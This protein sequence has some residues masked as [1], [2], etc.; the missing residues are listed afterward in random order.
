MKTI[1]L[2]RHAK[3][4][5]H[6][7]SISDF[8]RV[9]T[10]RGIMEAGEM[11][12]RLRE[13]GERPDLIVSSPAA[14]A[15]ETAE[16]F[17]ETLD[18]EPGMIRTKSEIYSGHIDVLEEVVRSLPGEIESVMIFGHNPTISLFGSWLANRGI[19]QMET[20]GVLRMD[21]MKK[22]WADLKKGCAAAVWYLQPVRRQ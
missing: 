21:M 18:Y 15:L 22:R 10:D 4:G 8:D 20:C 12:E 6:D 17:A 7:P 19:G 13:K 5:W 9:L 11:S 1:Y 14:R 16:I 3:A 2:V